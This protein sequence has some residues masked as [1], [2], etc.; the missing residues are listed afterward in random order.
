MVS[1]ITLD[2]FVEQHAV[3]RIDCIKI[4]AEGS[5]FEIIQGARSTIEKF[6]PI[7]CWKRTT[8]LVSGVQNPM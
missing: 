2:E 5:D 8:L 3:E 6:R 7:K 4:D 1:V